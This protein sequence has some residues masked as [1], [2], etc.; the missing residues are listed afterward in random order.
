MRVGPKGSSLPFAADG[1][2]WWEV[3][4]KTLVKIGPEEIWSPARKGR[5]EGRMGFEGVGGAWGDGGRGVRRVWHRVWH[6]FLV[7]VL[8]ES[9]LSWT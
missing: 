7:A 9:A 3:V 6:E 2:G 8:A 5:T 4:E 1:V